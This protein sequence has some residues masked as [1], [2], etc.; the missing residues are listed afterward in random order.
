M[1]NVN[2]GK[3]SV[4]NANINGLEK[5][6]L[7]SNSISVENSEIDVKKINSH[8]LVSAEHE[9]RGSGEYTSGYFP[10]K[11]EKQII[12]RGPSTLYIDDQSALY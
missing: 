10:Y 12:T 11:T 3:L 7:I 2:D 6:S 8:L 5:L 1:K 4:I 9:S